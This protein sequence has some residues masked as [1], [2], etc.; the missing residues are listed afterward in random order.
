VYK[1]PETR[2]NG[3]MR[4]GFIGLGNMGSAMARNLIR[5]GYEVTVYNRTADKA[6]SLEKDGATPAGTIAASCRSGIVLTMLADDP[7]VEETVF[8]SG[9]LLASLGKGDIHVC[10]STISLALARRLAEAHRE[11]GQVYVSAPVFGRPQAAEAAKLVVVAA[12]PA[13]AIERCQPA[14]EAVGHRVVRAG[15]Q[16]FQ[17]NV[18]KLC[19]NFMIMST[20]EATG[21]ALALCRK[22]GSSPAL[23]LDVMN[24]LFQS[25]VLN[26]YGKIILEQNYDPAGFKMKLGLKDARLVLAAGDEA[27][28]PM[29]I[30]SLVRDHYLSGLARGYGELDWAAL[31]KVV[32]EDAGIR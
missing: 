19:G 1:W 23:F 11:V 14:F 28:V 12:G 29:G 4:L 27:A 2:H 5:G 10:M 26:N 7:A 30:A 21:E 13:D 25:P 16:P 8:G 22:A 9:G 17:A 18:I 31:A 24:G 20:I 3:R 32:A 6:Q 15:D